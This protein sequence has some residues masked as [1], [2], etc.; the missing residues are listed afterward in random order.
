M[1]KDNV[2][3]CRDIYSK[4]MVVIALIGIFCLFFSGCTQ[5][6][7]PPTD[8]LVIL[9]HMLS[10]QKN[11]P[12]GQCR[13]MQANCGSKEFLSTNL[14]SGLYGETSRQWFNQQGNA[15]IDDV[16]IYISNQQ[17]PFEIAVFR[18]KN[19]VDISGGRGSVLGVCQNRLSFVQKAW[20]NTEFESYTR[21]GKV[22]FY[23][24]YVLVVIS[25]D[26]DTAI[27][28]AKKAIRQGSRGI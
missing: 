25:D 15:M 8:A 14:I 16:A 11:V 27:N 20:Q 3:R 2:Q 10:T 6:T 26:A 13:Y 23:G 9:E 18:C 7:L 28:A 24:Q 1:H 19:Q 21:Q 22:T 5:P 4:V 12:D 17:H